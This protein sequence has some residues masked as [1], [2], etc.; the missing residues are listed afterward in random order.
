M[1]SA[2]V[3]VAW[4]RR[5]SPTDL[6]SRRL[7]PQRNP[8]PPHGRF[9]PPSLA[10]GGCQPPGRRPGSGPQAGASPL[11]N[12]ERR[13]GLSQVRR[14]VRPIT[15]GG[16][17]EGGN[18]PEGALMARIRRLLVAALVLVAGLVPARTAKAGGLL[19][20]FGCGDCPPPSYSPFRY[21]TPG[22][23]RVY[24]CIHGPQL[25]VHAPD[26]HPE[27]KPTTLVLPFPCPAADPAD[28]IIERPKPPPESAF[29]YLGGG[30]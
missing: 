10:S 14:K 25:G 5:S 27:I 24:D 8:C 29:R 26:R 21:W 6:R 13:P 20:W 16:N 17:P 18:L 1:K 9:G 12:S 23:A 2:I 4:S 11:A 28:T 7:P 3:T 15:K 30:T 19:D 22:P